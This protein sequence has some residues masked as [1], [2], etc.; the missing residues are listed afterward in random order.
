MAQKYFVQ[1]GTR[2]RKTNRLLCPPLGCYLQSNAC[3][4]W[5]HFS[6]ILRILFWGS[7]RKWL[8]GRVSFH[9]LQVVL[10][11]DPESLVTE[12][13]YLNY[14]AANTT[15]KHIYEDIYGPKLT[16][17]PLRQFFSEYLGFIFSNFV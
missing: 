11:I 4:K 16:R 13:K 1:T 8:F 7:L 3:G 10:T 2:R 15:P 5:V 9:D 17:S 12:L 6:G 14:G